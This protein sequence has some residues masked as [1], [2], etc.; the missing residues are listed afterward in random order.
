MFYLFLVFIIAAGPAILMLRYVYRM[1]TIEKEPRDLIRR[2]IIFG[3]VSVIP[4]IILEMI[5]GT[6]LDRIPNLTQNSYIILEMFCVVAISEE[7]CKFMA[8]KLVSWKNPN[9]NYMF[10]GMLYAICV[11]IGF[12]V[13]EDIMYIFQSGLSTGIVR[14]LTFIPGHFGFAVFSGLIYSKARESANRGE[15]GKAF[16]YMVL[17]VVFAA[18]MHGFYDSCLSFGTGI[19]ILLFFAFVIVMYIAV[20]KMIKKASLTDHPI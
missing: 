14:A 19:S 20:F 3:A 11:A 17:A 5:G 7:L 18:V 2:L 1:D 8:L 4:A 9:F 6:I 13:L 15:D 12:S 16:G 10:D